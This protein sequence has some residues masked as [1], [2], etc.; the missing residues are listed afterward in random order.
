MPVIFTPG[1]LVIQLAT[2]LMTD[3]IAIRVYHLKNP[4]IFKT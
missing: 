3:P 2:V 1:P 4:N